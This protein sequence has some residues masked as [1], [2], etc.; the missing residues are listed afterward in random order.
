MESDPFLKYLP[1]QTAAAAFVLANHT[2]TGG[3]WVSLERRLKAA[4]RLQD[5]VL[6]A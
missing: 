3:A 2:L 1:S 6:R 4:F 5:C